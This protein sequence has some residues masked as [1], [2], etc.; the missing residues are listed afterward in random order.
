MNCSD[1]ERMFDSYLDGL[2]SGT[3]R[4]EFDAHR[5]RCRRCQQT[6]AMLESV[7]HVIASDRRGP[8]LTTDFTDRVMGVIRQRSSERLALRRKRWLRVALVV[9]GVMQA[10]AVLVFAVIWGAGR[11]DG[12]SRSAVASPVVELAVGP[13]EPL[14]SD[15]SADQLREFIYSRLEQ[16]LLA[17]KNLSEQGRRTLMYLN[18]DVPDPVARATFDALPLN[19]LTG[20][21]NIVLPASVESPE[22]VDPDTGRFSL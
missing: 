20:W 16:A 17:Q 18:L 4:L 1:A 19:P 3:L 13:A 14:L 7:G 12:G 2:L 8:M 10:A 21:L 9:G 15:M 6:L 11:D 22:I 5:L